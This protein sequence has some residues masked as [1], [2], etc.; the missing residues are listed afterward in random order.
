MIT[1]REHSPTIVEKT[2]PGGRRKE[3]VPLQKEKKRMKKGAMADLRFTT[4][5]MEAVVYK[6]RC[7]NGR[8]NSE[9]ELLQFLNENEKEA[10]ASVWDSSIMNIV[11]C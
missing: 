1:G 10:D 3:L 8:S 11:Y 6:M 4:N 2:K 5:D 9:R 7:A